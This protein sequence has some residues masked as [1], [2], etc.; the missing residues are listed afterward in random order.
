MKQT[1]NILSPE[2]IRDNLISYFRST[3]VVPIVG[4]GLSCGLFTDRGV[5]PNGTE[6]RRHMLTC[7]KKTSSFSPDEE[8]TLERGNFSSL[9]D[10][11]EDDE[12][13]PEKTR[14]DYL[15]ANFYHVRFSRS[16][17]RMKFFEI[18]W[19]YIYSL[20]IDD[21][22]ENSTAYNTLI[23]PNRDF[24]EDQFTEE[25]C[26][27]KLHGDINEIVRYTQSEKVFTSKEYA[28]SLETN[29]AILR[30][31]K[32]DYSNQNILFVGCS[33]DDE[34]DLKALSAL[35]LDYQ[36]K[37]NLTQTMLFRE[38]TPGRLE[39]SK[40][41]TY[42]ITD[43]VCF[44]NY[45]EL[46]SFLLD[47]WEESQR[48]PPDELQ[49]YRHIPL[50]KLSV[51]EKKENHDYFFWGKGLFNTKEKVLTYPYFFISRNVVNSILQNL[52]RNK[53]H[54][55]CGSHI[56]GK[57]YLLADLYRTIKDRTVYYFDGKSRLSQVA[58]QK[59]LTQE[60][61]A[62]L[63]D[64][65]SLNRNQFEEIITNAQHIK[66]LK[67]NFIIA[68]NQS[69]GDF[70]GVVKWK[71]KQRIIAESDIIRYDVNNVLSSQKEGN[72]SEQSR[73]NALLPA[74]GLLPFGTKKTILDELIYAEKALS[75][76]GQYA[77][78]HICVNSA[79]GLALL[80]ILAI[81]ERMS[82]L[83]LVTFD[84]IKEMAEAL[85]RYTPFLEEC[86]TE[87]YERGPADLSSVKYVVNSK[88]WLQ[89][90]LGQYAHV[91]ENHSMIAKAYRYIIQML[92]DSSGN[93]IQDRYRRCRDYIMFDVMNNIFL[94]EHQGNL[95][96]TVYI[97][98][99]L[100]DLLSQDYN[101]LH[102]NAKCYM[103]YAYYLSNLSEKYNWLQKS[104]D[105]AIIAKTMVEVRY[106]K[107][108]NERLLISLAHIQYTIATIFCEIC[109]AQKYQNPVDIEKAIDS[110]CIAL[111]SPYNLDD[112][113]R[114][115]KKSG[116]HGI[117]S[118]LKSPQP[119]RASGISDR[120]ISRYTELINRYIYK[121]I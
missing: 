72:S 91:K 113:K 20:N 1:L 69:D 105:L 89:R 88:Y 71:T 77:R 119:V 42:G 98:E 103:N 66:N 87:G 9:C 93:N 118:F 85:K 51:S 28:L 79:K 73:I 29:A 55:L 83:T 106:D 44:N 3:S 109:I 78:Q 27:I 23:L 7:L 4:A 86:D 100:H 49:A 90:E 26:L 94:D 60:S 2:Q 46:Y 70:L 45:E 117:I 101:F 75:A 57:T 22:I 21:S 59:L 104:S 56:S 80:I 33:L 30:K 14:L 112:Y 11:Y 36:A 13:V 34:I 18:G 114:D 102:Q 38:G 40:Y 24:R 120:Y 5:V 92:L 8:S 76:K 50:A 68:V 16:D 12:I 41:K 84:L 108:H 97:Y 48:I 37:R 35:S 96:L 61:T 115:T 116:S 67:S 52:D 15:K 63:L 82:S 25:K 65:G 39:K 53:I 64:V 99:Q 19:P 47:T 111:L 31:L 107:F 95:G 10:Y 121:K 81:Q 43:V 17:M 58:L 110:I 62:V 54:L 6:F 74:V 32:N